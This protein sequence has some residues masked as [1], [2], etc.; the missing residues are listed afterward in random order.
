MFAKSAEILPKVISD[1]TEG[2]ITPRLQ[3]HAIAEY[4]NLIKKEDGYFDIDNPPSPEVL[5]R[6]IRAY[7]PW[8]TTWT[9]WRVKGQGLGVKERIVKFLPEGKIQME[10]KKPVHLKDFLNGYPDFPIKNL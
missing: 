1:F 3:D 6:M 4:C 10:G 5:D 7:Y 9:L 2:K 8:P